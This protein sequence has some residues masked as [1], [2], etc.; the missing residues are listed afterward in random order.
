[1]TEAESIELSEAVPAKSVDDRLIDE[2]V[3]RAQAEGLQLTGE[4]GLLQQ[5]TKRLLESALEGEITDHLGY[6]K[7]DPAGKNGGNS[8]NGTR[9]KTVLTDVGPVEITVPRDREGSFEPKIV[10]KRQKRLSGVDEMVISLAA[11]GLTTG[12]VQ[13]HL[14][15]VYGADVSRQTISTITDK[16]LEGMAEWQN[17]PLDAVYPVVFIDAIHVKIRDGAVANRPIYVALAVTAEGRRDILG[18]WAGDGGEGAKHWMH[19]LTEIKNRGVNDVLMLVCDGLKGLPDAVEAVWPKTIVQTCVVH[20]L[21]NS[22]RYAAR[23]DWDKIAKL[24]KPVYTAATEEAALG[25]FAEFAD[26]WG[27]KYP[28]IVRL[29]ENAWEE[30][31]PFLRFDTEIRRIVCTTNAIESVNARIRRAVKARGHFPNE[32]AALKCV[33]MAIMSLD[34]TGKGQARW[35]MRWKTALNAFDITFDG[36]LSA[37]RQ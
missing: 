17:R 26:A 33:Y 12:E 19:I 14:A 18:L 30:F 21:R 24:L 28:A 10:K 35:T 11:K 4:G 16:V 20:L 32:Q 27:R 15:E 3:S 9:T 29:W 23:Q 13:A 25:R 2:L 36:R 5:L 37:A 1:M 34:P 7:H 31:T 6:D 8:R 22:F